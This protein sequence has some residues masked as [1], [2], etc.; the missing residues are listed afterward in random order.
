MINNDQST[1]LYC[2]KDVKLH[3]SGGDTVP[4]NTLTGKSF[5]VVI[6]HKIPLSSMINNP[7]K[8]KN[9]HVFI[10][11]WAVTLLNPGK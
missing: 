2:C 9:V 4:L 1:L 5:N 8:I 11:F 3:R 6:C 7:L 10:P